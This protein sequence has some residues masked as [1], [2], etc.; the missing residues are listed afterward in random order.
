MSRH[1]SESLLSVLPLPADLIF[2]CMCS[3]AVAVGFGLG[4]Q[5][6]GKT[7]AHLDEDN[8]KARAEGE[9]EDTEGWGGRE[10]RGFEGG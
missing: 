4:Q 8:D 9:G 2:L 5:F 10:S 3:L 7:I 6:I 1:D